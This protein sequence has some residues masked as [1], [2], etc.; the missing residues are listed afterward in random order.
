MSEENITT[1]M[2]ISGQ[3]E[4]DTH[5]ILDR[6]PARKCFMYHSTQKK[7]GV[8]PWIEKEQQ[9]LDLAKCRLSVF[10]LFFGFGHRFQRGTASISTESVEDF[11]PSLEEMID[12]I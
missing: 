10:G 4:Q 9:I 11:L 7:R 12:Y 5:D 6:R 8:P 2:S 1:P 3:K